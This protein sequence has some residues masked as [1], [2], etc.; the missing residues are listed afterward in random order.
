MSQEQRK[1]MRVDK[2]ALVAYEKIGKAS[3]ETAD[4]GMAKT[5]DVSVRGLLL[6]FPRPVETG[7]HLRLELSLDGEVV[8]VEGVVVRTDRDDAGLDVA[9]VHLTH[10]P[11]EYVGRIR[12]LAHQL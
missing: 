4:A 10:V 5:L 8:K 6:E 9:G 11:Q 2:N 1:F 12:D 7:D 3:A